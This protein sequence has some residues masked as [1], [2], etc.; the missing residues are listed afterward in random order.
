M[1]GAPEVSVVI[2]T[3][4]RATRLAAALRALHGQTIA[5]DRFEVVVVDDGSSDETAELL[6]RQA[7]DGGPELRTIRLTG[8]GPAAARNAGWRAA[9]SPLVA[10]TD[11][12]CEPTPTWLEE[13]L[14]AAEASAGAI[15]QGVTTPI[16][17][18]TEMLRRP[19]SRTRLIDEPNP[20]F[21][22]CNIAYPRE[23]LERLDGFDEIFPE[24][25]GEDTDLGWRALEMGAFTE[26]A[27][28]AVVH[29]AV[30][31]L[32]PAGYM[33]HALRGADAV[34]AFR[35]HP[36]LR[37]EILRHGV[38]RNPSLERLALALAGLLLARGHRAALLLTLPYAR[39][40]IG[41]SRSTDAGPALVPYLLAYDL[42]QAYTSLRG[43]IR[44]RRLVL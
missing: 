41:R 7:V 8:E 20:W 28:G 23:L 15:V 39:N 31:D 10:F 43:S 36:G 11:D 16:P 9:R 2:P 35:R 14:G 3:R 27:P 42:A 34:Y 1:S 29:H 18:E 22:T 32:G 37:A 25:L 26:F 17:R 19:F 5:P 40:L 44:H 6:A 21:A 12:D 33:R 30:E 4:D 24:A 38:F 13:I